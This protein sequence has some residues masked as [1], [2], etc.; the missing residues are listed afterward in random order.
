[1]FGDAFD[2][3]PSLGTAT[4]R[5]I[6]ASKLP[7]SSSCAAALFEATC[8]M[9]FFG[10]KLFFFPASRASLNEVLVRAPRARFL[11]MLASAVLVQHYF[12]FLS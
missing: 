9:L 11:V 1:M 3:S 12:Q 7:R 6:L 4:R 2:S 5:A 10:G 8:S